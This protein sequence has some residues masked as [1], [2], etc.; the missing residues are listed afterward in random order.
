MTKIY[1]KDFK[2]TVYLNIDSIK[3][4]KSFF[5]DLLFK[6]KDI[7]TFKYDF[8]NYIISKNL[9]NYLDSNIIISE[10]EYALKIK[11]PAISEIKTYSEFIQLKN[12]FSAV[13]D[14]IEGKTQ[15]SITPPPLFFFRTGEIILELFQSKNPESSEISDS[16]IKTLP[17]NIETVSVDKYNSTV[18]Y[19]AKKEGYLAL[20]NGEITICSPIIISND[21]TV[22]TAVIF[23]DVFIKSHLIEYFFD[24]INN[25]YTRYPDAPLKR[26]PVR[27]TIEKEEYEIFRI[28][29]AEGIPAVNGKDALIEFFF[30]ETETA[31]KSEEEINYKEFK[32]YTVVKKDDLLFRKSKAEEGIPGINIFG[33]KQEVTNGNDI[34]ISINENIHSEEHDT[35]IDYYS[36]TD[37]LFKYIDDE[38]SVEEVM[39]IN[40][41]LDYRTG[42]IDYPKSIQIKGDVLAGFTVKSGKNIIIEGCVENGSVIESREDLIVGKGIIGSETKII[43]FGDIYTGYILESNIYCEGKTVIYNHAIGGSI[44]S[45]E[46]LNVLGKNMKNT[47]KASIFGGKYYSMKKIELLS[48]GNENRET[49][50][51]SGYNPYME[52]KLEEI[53]KALATLDIKISEI[54]Y[55][56][57]DLSHLSFQPENIKK[58]KPDEKERIKNKLIILKQLTE[59]KSSL[60]SLCSKYKDLIFAKDEDKPFIKIKKFIFPV[61]KIQ[62]IKNQKTI[63][64]KTGKR[65]FDLLE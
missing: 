63:A 10:P 26:M 64:K 13:P 17:S 9:Y 22:I 46:S 5:N 38:A 30:D 41:D 28:S 25:F 11:F 3:D 57:R 27:E 35:F 58:M 34:E 8:I 49:L 39:L 1:D 29:I 21:K 16:P 2:K 14:M 42:N 18:I 12:I 62:L 43:C 55:A 24:Y 53:R 59:T 47:A 61:V 7:K 23:P 40:G 54:M 19:K 33:E 6:Y 60:N 4:K 32:K 36:T 20:K 31:D 65:V 48:A 44:F 45:R 37:G 50:L 51:C 56:L 52:N 15:D